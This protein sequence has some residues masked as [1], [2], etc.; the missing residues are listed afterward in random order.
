MKIQRNLLPTLKNELLNT[1]K[2]LVI[3]GPRQVGKTT[4]INDLLSEFKW[5]TLILNGDQRGS[6]WELL[7]SRELSKL[8]LLVS[9]YDAI[10][11][12]EAQRIP[13]I[14]LSLKILL[15]SFP[16][17]KIV[18]TG[19]SALDLASKISEPLTGRIYSYKLFPISCGELR[20]MN[21]PY[22]ME[23]QIEERLIFGSYPEIFSLNGAVLKSKYLQNL[24]D[25]HLYK[26]LLEFGDIRNSS[27]IHDLLRL[28]AFQAGSQVSLNELGNSLEL[29]RITVERYIDLLEKSFIV[30]RLSGFSRNLRKEVSKMDKIYFYDLGV[31]N[32]IIGNLNVLKSRDDAGKLWENFLII[33]RMK[34]LQY[35][36]KIFSL[37]FWRLSSGAEMDLIE[38]VNGQLHGYEFKY[39][40]KAV[41]T[42]SSWA[43]NYPGARATLINQ[44]NWQNFVV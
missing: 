13:E 2:G 30:F 24:V 36:Q 10:F 22:E 39:G 8:T 4:L 40:K 35:E 11:I 9:G 7:T 28:L 12:D 25:T 16:K 31:R 21:T 41:K 3:Y 26:D 37:Y 34:K 20:E 5:R 43:I 14:G 18:V 33:E 17:L 29:N 23:T 38:E 1:N 15:D 44:E 6:W 42:P 19:S 27:K 32:A